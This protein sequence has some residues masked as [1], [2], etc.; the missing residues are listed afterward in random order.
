MSAPGLDGAN[1]LVTGGTGSLG[2]ALVRRLLADEL[3]RPASVTVFSR[4]EA[5]QHDLR[6]ALGTAGA[7]TEEAAY[8]DLATRLRFRIGSVTDRDALLPA[9]ARADVV[10]HA[11][12][13][14]QVPTCERFPTEAVRTNVDGAHNLVR[15]IADHRLPVHTVVGVSTDKACE[16]VNVMGM[17]KAIQERVLMGGNL[18]APDTRFVLTRY[19][20]VM[21]SRGSAIPLFAHQIRAGEPLTLTSSA[22]TRFLM[23]IEDAVDMVLATYADARAGETLVP[24]L[25]SARIADVIDALLAGRRMPV[26]ITGVRP[27]EKVHEVLI[28]GEEAGRTGE[29]GGHLAIAPLLP[30]MRPG[31]GCGAAPPALSGEL[32]SGDDPMEPDAVRALLDR[33]G[34]LED[35]PGTTA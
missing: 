34:L 6:V 26:I 7:D 16:P 15:L 32:S 23:G 25:P 8:H 12:A 9:L 24:R 14:K 19:G 20:N 2:S 33:H 29:R 28:S 3:H 30:E 18:E 4:D 27:G 10:M 22:M 35:P 21:A 5:K 17:T 11:A 13:L 1:V 31:T